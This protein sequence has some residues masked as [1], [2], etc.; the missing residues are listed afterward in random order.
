MGATPAASFQPFGASLLTGLNS[1]LCWYEFQE[2]TY[3]IYSISCLHPDQRK[4]DLFDPTIILVLIIRFMW[5]EPP[6]TQE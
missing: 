1:T 4:G 5:V 3:E 2:A 6:K